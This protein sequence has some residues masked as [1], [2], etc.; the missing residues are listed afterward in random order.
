MFEARGGA[1]LE[2]MEVGVLHDIL[3]LL[4]ADV[5]PGKPMQFVGVRLIKARKGSVSRGH[6]RPPRVARA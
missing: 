3:R 1:S 6:K 5:A 4:A 2:E